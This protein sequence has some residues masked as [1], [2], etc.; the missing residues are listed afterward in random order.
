LRCA[1]YNPTFP[2]LQNRWPHG[3]GLGLVWYMCLDF[4]VQV[5][6]WGVYS[7]GPASPSQQYTPTLSSHSG[8][9]YQLATEWV[10]DIDTRSFIHLA[11]LQC[12]L[13][14]SNYGHLQ[15]EDTRRIIGGLACGRSFEG[16]SVVFFAA[17]QIELLDGIRARSIGSSP[18][19]RTGSEEALHCVEGEGC[20]IQAGLHIYTK[21][22]KQMQSLRILNLCPVFRM[23]LGY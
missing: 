10:G 19:P 6:T 20:R 15:E 1:D 23:P 3:N 8:I 13:P 22:N 5:E 16:G 12:R 18:M 14:H 7:V 4:S 11:C 9:E 21:A 2:F 17:R